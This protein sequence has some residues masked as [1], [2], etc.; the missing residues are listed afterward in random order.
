MSTHDQDEKVNEKEIEAGRERRSYEQGEA[1]EK[2]LGY[3]TYEHL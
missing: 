2:V 3:D 1:K